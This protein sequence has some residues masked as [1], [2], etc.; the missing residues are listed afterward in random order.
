MAAPVIVIIG[1][2]TSLAVTLPWRCWRTETGGRH[3]RRKNCRVQIAFVRNVVNLICVF[4]C[5]SLL[6]TDQGFALG[7]AVFSK[8]NARMTIW[9]TY[10]SVIS[11]SQDTPLTLSISSTTG[12]S[13][14]VRP[15]TSNKRPVPP[16]QRCKLSTCG[17]A[18]RRTH[19]QEQYGTPGDVHRPPVA[20]LVILPFP[21]QFRYKLRIHQPFRETWPLR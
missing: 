10:W 18:Y 15:S 13:S 1:N 16:G 4:S 11:T 8:S 21:E 7:M 9:V 5:L 2:S 20:I 3:W 19:R 12:I 17:P 14:H 6:L